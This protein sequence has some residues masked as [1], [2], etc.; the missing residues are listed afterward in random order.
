[1]V[2]IAGKRPVLLSASAIVASYHFDWADFRDLD[3]WIPVLEAGVLT[4]RCS[5]STMDELDAC[6]GLLAALIFRRPASAALP[7]LATRVL[8]LL[9]GPGD[10]NRRMT[11][12]AL[13]LSYCYLAGDVDIPE[14]VRVIA[15][16]LLARPEATPYAVAFWHGR[17]ALHFWRTH[18]WE[19]CAA[20]NYECTRHCEEH[21]FGALMTW[22]Y[23]NQIYLDTLNEDVRGMEKTLGRMRASAKLGRIQ[24][25]YFV[26]M[27]GASVAFYREQFPRALSICRHA[28]KLADRSGNARMAMA[29]RSWLAC[30]LA[31]T[32]QVDEIET[33]IDEA[34]TMLVGTP[35]LALRS[36]FSLTEAFV[37]IKQG[38]K[39]QAHEIIRKIFSDA[40]ARE[41]LSEFIPLGRHVLTAVCK[42]ALRVGIHADEAREI[43]QRFNL[44]NDDYS[45]EAWPWRLRIH[46]LGR[47]TLTI[48]NQLPPSTGKSPVRLRE[49]LQRLVV[50]GR[51]R[52]NAAVLA[53]EIWPDLEGDAAARNI[54]VAISRL[55]KLLGVS[56]AVIFQDQRVTLNT[57]CCWVDVWAFH[58]MTARA[59]SAS[60]LD[61]EGMLR[62]LI[63]LYA[64]HFLE[65]EG[66]PSWLHCY[67]EA[68]R[69]RWRTTAEDLGHC[70]EAD[71]RTTEAMIH[72]SQIIERDPVAEEFYRRQMRLQLQIGNHVGAEETYRRCRNALATKFAVEPSPSTEAI[73]KE[74]RH[75][76]K[77]STARA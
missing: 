41:D 36:Q 39:T 58:D 14:R 47:F 30:A 8:R 38:D 51:S 70:L 11:A 49:I 63:A 56:N 60:N 19:D 73:Y 43:A 42:E 65:S 61:K 64:G 45:L 3:R 15:D 37:A 57:R 75:T 23:L 67:R 17:L 46:T 16:R 20:A 29:G 68:A 71:Q 26:A 66:D 54:E 48:D 76:F 4:E 5:L 27:F 52:I 25:Q 22:C 12:A 72:Y 24:D 10:T 32:S 74:V 13:L 33:V 50:A 35:F 44:G 77:T 7:K 59:S 18:Q 28:V 62:A 1:M 34:R 53:E 55:R 31:H 6:A 9:E 21:G 2:R 69:A 40:R